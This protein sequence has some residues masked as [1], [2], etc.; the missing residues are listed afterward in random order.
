[1]WQTMNLTTYNFV[2]VQQKRL[3]EEEQQQKPTQYRPVKWK[4]ISI[5]AEN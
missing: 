5:A 2:N 1:M 4:Q 3:D